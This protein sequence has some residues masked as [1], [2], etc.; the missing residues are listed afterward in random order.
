MP[1]MSGLHRTRVTSS[2]T[3]TSWRCGG[4]CSLAQT[5]V[6]AILG[7]LVPSPSHSPTQCCNAC[8]GLSYCGVY[9][10]RSGGLF[11]TPCVRG[12]RT[13]AELLLLFLLLWFPWGCLTLGL[14]RRLTVK[15]AVLSSHFCLF[16]VLG[17][18]YLTYWVTYR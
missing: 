2:H 5:S 9:E 13:R 14:L 17:K 18:P 6:L 7:T 15:L 16:Q 12:E 1:V 3:G 8:Q 4:P 11:L 10:Y